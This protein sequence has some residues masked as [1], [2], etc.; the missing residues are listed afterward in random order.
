MYC[1]KHHDG[2]ERTK[3]VKVKQIKERRQLRSI[4]F[5]PKK[6]IEDITPKRLRS[7]VSFYRNKVEE[8][9]LEISYLRRTIQ[10]QNA[11]IEILQK[12]KN[13]NR[14]FKNLK[15]KD[16]RFYRREN[17]RQTE[18]EIDMESKD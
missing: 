10:I 12:S 7:L 9:L 18:I 11:K 15:I 13:A 4:G 16:E 14:N 8:L 2:K 1:R 3:M 5:N 6:P 17:D